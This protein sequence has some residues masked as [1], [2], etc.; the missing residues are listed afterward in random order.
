MHL[1][2]SLRERG[3][4]FRTNLSTGRQVFVLIH[5]S[6]RLRSGNI[7][8]GI[9]QRVL[10]TSKSLPDHHCLEQEVR[11]PR[12]L[13]FL[14]VFGWYDTHELNVADVTSMF[15]ALCASE[16]INCCARLLC[17]PSTHF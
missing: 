13:T 5:E 6:N 17:H 16:D 4:D 15:C 3:G 14:S 7:D 10:S 12:L 11:N 9:T 8:S 2:G 1:A